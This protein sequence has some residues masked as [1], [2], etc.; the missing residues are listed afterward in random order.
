MA[1][2]ESRCGFDEVNARE[3]CG[4]KCETNEECGVGQQCYPTLLNLCD[5]FEEMDVDGSI[6]DIFANASSTIEP[7]FLGALQTGGG[8]PIATESD[9]KVEG[10]PRN[11]SPVKL[12]GIASLF[13]SLLGILAVF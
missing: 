4:Q 13:V 7:Y 10:K 1:G 6:E 3:H 8:S 5:C 12:L 2:Q 11:D 9:G